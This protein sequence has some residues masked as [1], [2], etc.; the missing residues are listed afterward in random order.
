ML[1]ELGR[2]PFR[3]QTKSHLKGLPFSQLLENSYTS[4]NLVLCWSKEHQSPQLLYQKPL[5]NKASTRRRKFA[6]Q[7]QLC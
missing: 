1:R 5:L 7:H 3:Q 4:V 6:L 2:R